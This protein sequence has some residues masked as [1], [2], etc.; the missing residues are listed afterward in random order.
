VRCAV[1]QEAIEAVTK[2]LTIHDQIMALK[3]G[4]DGLLGASGVGLSGGE[5]QRVLLA[6]A[7]LRVV[8]QGVCGD[9]DVTVGS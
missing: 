5:R 3:G 7:L 9:G 2:A 4:Y 1:P 6:N 8:F